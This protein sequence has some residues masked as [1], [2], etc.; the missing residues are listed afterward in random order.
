MRV[1]PAT[2]NLGFHRG[3]AIGGPGHRNWIRRAYGAR[4]RQR[5]IGRGLAFTTAMVQLGGDFHRAPLD[6][7]LVLMDRDPEFRRRVAHGGAE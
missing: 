6:G 1:V 3:A 4:R 7:G 2:G 5:F